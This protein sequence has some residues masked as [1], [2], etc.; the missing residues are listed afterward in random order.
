MRYEAQPDWWRGDCGCPIRV[1]ESGAAYVPSTSILW[2]PALY[3]RL[4]PHPS[5]TIWHRLEYE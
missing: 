3:G 2:I 4:T 5:L 1:F